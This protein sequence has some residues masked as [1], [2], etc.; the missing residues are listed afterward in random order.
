M[1]W[2]LPQWSFIK[3][4]EFGAP[5]LVTPY[6]CSPHINGPPLS[7]GHTVCM[8]GT[9]H[10][11]SGLIVCIELPVKL[12]GKRW[13]KSDI[14]MF[15]EREC[16]CTA[17]LGLWK[18]VSLIDWNITFF[19]AFMHDLWN[20]QCCIEYFLIVFK[21]PTGSNSQILKLYKVFKLSFLVTEN[22]F[23]LIYLFFCISIY[24]FI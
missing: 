20:S 6:W 9:E 10:K 23:V 21:I 3:M 16:I 12:Y 14:K 15:T 19:T 22:F 4:F 7:P 17:I 2:S 18:I 13:K 5:L 1:I 8:S 24:S 11:N